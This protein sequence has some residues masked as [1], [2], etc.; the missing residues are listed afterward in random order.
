MIKGFSV[1]MIALF[2]I[3]LSA[4]TIEIEGYWLPIK[5]SPTVQHCVYE[6]NSKDSKVRVVSTNP[7]ILP[8]LPRGVKKVMICDGTVASKSGGTANLYGD[9]KLK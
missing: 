4:E 1:F 9:C 8:A 2:T 6:G 3:P 5:R 7:C